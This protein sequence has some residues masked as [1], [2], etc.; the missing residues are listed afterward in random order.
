[1][2]LAALPS[3]D[4]K[5]V[6][7]DSAPSLLRLR[8]AVHDSVVDASSADEELGTVEVEMLAPQSDHLTPPHPR[9]DDGQPYGLEPVVGGV[10]EESAELLGR[11]NRHVRVVDRWGSANAATLPARRPHAPRP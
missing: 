5:V 7:A 3:W 11:P 8:F 4:T 6:E 9:G 10:G 1:M 2:F